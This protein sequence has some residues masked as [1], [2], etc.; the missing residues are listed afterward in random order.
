MTETT[1]WSSRRPV[2]DGTDDRGE[3]G[4][5]YAAAGDLADDAADIRRRAG[6]GQ[7]RNQCAQNLSS[8]AAAHCTGDGISKRTEIDVL[9]RAGGDIAADRAADDLDD[10]VNKH[11][12]HGVILPRS[13]DEFQPCARRR[14][15]AAPKANL[16]RSVG[17]V[18]LHALRMQ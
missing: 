5:G 3:D 2:L 11:S 10:Q 18:M 4:T 14:T 7:Q 12:R 13:G 8:D 16:R 6:I 9:G 15:I 1:L 17:E